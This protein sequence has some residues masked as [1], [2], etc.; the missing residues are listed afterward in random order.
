[1]KGKE[2]CFLLEEILIDPFQCQ[3]LMLI[4]N[5]EY[6]LPQL[7]KIYF[8][9]KTK[10]IEDFLI[11]KSLY[12]FNFGVKMILILNSELNENPNDIKLNKF[13]NKVET[14]LMEPQKHI[15]K[16]KK[17]SE[18]EKRLNVFN[19]QI[20]FLYNL[21]NLSSRLR[22]YPV[23]QIRNQKLRIELE[24]IQIS[25]LIYFPFL[26]E[27]DE[28][29]S[30]LKIN[31][32]ISTCFSTRERVPYLIF[33]ETLIH[34][35]TN[36]KNLN[37]MKE[38][39][40][41]ED[42]IINSSVIFRK[43]IKKEEEFL[44][45]QLFNQKQI[46][47][48]EHYF[49]LKEDEDIYEDDD[50]EDETDKELNKVFGNKFEKLKKKIRKQSKFGRLKNWNL[51]TFIV[52]SNDDLRQ[53]TL[54]LQLLSLF[55]RIFEDEKLPIFIKDYNSIIIS[56][57]SG[58]LETLLDSISIDGLKKKY[59]NF[60]NLL[61]YFKA[62]YQK[63]FNKHVEKFIES[64]CGYSLYC[65]LFQVKDRHNG[66]IMINR[67][68]YIYHIDFGFFLGD[69]PGGNL[70]Q[71]E[72]AP[73]K[74]TSDYVELMGGKTSDLFNYFRLLMFIGFKAIRK[75]KEEIL[76]LVRLIIDDETKLKNLNER[77]HSNLNDNEF[78]KFVNNLIDE[79]ID[80]FRTVQYDNYQKLT[81]GIL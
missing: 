14:Q 25:N 5:L 45:N 66:N 38:F 63:N 69:F 52:K 73:F 41:D 17:I 30:I 74:L 55:K 62:I 22:E 53:E 71:F 21:T 59:K 65:Y 8:K 2:I 68:G 28:F 70:L 20:H 79:S 72:S 4:E 43:K 58:L 36:C 46:K 75:Y 11:E 37:S 29:E 40:E 78:E 50:E 77:F 67:D 56:N 31:S 64:L 18:K 57:E 48:N 61:D 7:M 49:L 47:V 44:S 15:E 60:T 54:S 27:N 10:D 33:F 3:K 51:R 16:L 35:N 12:S 9:S 39:N 34:Q 19:E 76:R 81:N 32:S 6:Y 13:R 24:K 42:L 80:N 26:N 23:G 1:M